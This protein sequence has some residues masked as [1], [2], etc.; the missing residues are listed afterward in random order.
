MMDDEDSNIS[1]SNKKKGPALGSSTQSQFLDLFLVVLAFFILFV[2]VSEFEE[3]KLKVVVNSLNSV[4]RPILPATSDPTD[5]T[6][7][8]GRILAAEEFQGHIEGLFST[9]LGVEKTEIVEP[10]RLMRVVMQADALFESGTTKLKAANLPLLDRLVTSLSGRPPGF[11]FDME[12][13]IGSK[14]LASGLLPVSQSLQ[15]ERAGAFIR[16][17]L[18]RGVP[19]EAISIGIQE[20]KPDL[21]TMWFHIRAPSE[22]TAYYDKLENHGKTATEPENSGPIPV[23]GKNGN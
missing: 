5:F 13:V 23:G 22:I 2:S 12:F 16:N 6:S 17:M 11:H 14:V 20:G 4:F 7:N 18:S 3:V 15:M 1:G 9:P 21:V 19:P 8:S 10:G